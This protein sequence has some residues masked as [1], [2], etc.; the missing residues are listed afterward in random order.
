MRPHNVDGLLHAT[1][2]RNHVFDYQDFLTRRDLEAAAKYKLPLF[3]LHKNEPRAQLP[4][5]LLANHQTAHCR[6]DDGPHIQ[7][8]NS[9]GKRRPQPLNR[10]HLLERNGTLKE[11]P[12][13]E[14]ASKK[15]VA[16]EERTGFAKN[17]QGL[18]LVH[19]RAIVMTGVG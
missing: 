17:L 9:V 8:A 7:R 6:S 19:A 14:S 5:N 3:L 18:V 15:E 2:F 4:G 10:G 16:F 1:A 12:A 13:V 11:L